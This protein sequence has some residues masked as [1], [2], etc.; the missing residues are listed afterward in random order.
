M[1]S[2]L[3]NHDYTPYLRDSGF[4]ENLFPSKL[5]S[6]WLHPCFNSDM[7]RTE[8]RIQY[9]RPKDIHYPG[10]KFNTGHLKKKETTYKYM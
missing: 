5:N 10:P 6:A 8:Y 1:Q 4:S 3:G 7:T 2:S 9:N